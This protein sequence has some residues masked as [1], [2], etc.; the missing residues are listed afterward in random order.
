MYV[1]CLRDDLGAFLLIKIKRDSF[2]KGR[3]YDNMLH[4][5][6]LTIFGRCSTKVYC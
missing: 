3:M 5:R 1:C 2:R 6:G 4:L